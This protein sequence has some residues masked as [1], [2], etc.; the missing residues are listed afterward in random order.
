MP[1]IEVVKLISNKIN[2]PFFGEKKAGHL[3]RTQTITVFLTL[4]PS[5]MQ[6]RGIVDIKKVSAGNMKN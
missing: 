4:Q 6:Y 1:C 2:V 3:V 5:T